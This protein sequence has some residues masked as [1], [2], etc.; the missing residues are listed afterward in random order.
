MP[1]PAGIPC[2][3]CK[4]TGREPEGAREDLSKTMVKHPQSEG[5]DVHKLSENE[6][7]AHLKGPTEIDRL[8]CLFVHTGL[9]PERLFLNVDERHL[10]QTVRIGYTTVEEFQAILAGYIR[11]HGNVPIT[12]TSNR[13]C[14]VFV[15]GEHS[16]TVWLSFPLVPSV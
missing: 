10:F 14:L 8:I 7:E 13:S 9:K 2:S 11:F 1:L 12:L 5:M 15:Q 3:R 4:G 6:Y 16:I